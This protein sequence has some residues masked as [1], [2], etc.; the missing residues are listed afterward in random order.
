L[1]GVPSNDHRCDPEFVDFDRV[2]SSLVAYRTSLLCMGINPRA[3]VNVDRSTNGQNRFVDFPRIQLRRAWTKRLPDRIGQPLYQP[4]ERLA[5][6][7]RV[8][9]RI[10]RG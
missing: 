9:A 3:G 4:T 7:S 6:L 1:A 10:I 8:I 5:L 2:M